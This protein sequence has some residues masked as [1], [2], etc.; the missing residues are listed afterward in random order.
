MKARITVDIPIEL[1]EWAKK[2]CEKKKISR[3]MLFEQ[4]LEAYKAEVEDET[5]KGEEK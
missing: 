4:A 2:Y 3:N 1:L 5:S